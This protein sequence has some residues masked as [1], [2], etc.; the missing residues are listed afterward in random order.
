MSSRYFDF[1]ETIESIKAVDDAGRNHRE[2]LLALD[3]RSFSRLFYGTKSTAAFM[4]RFEQDLKAAR[5]ERRNNYT[6]MITQAKK[7]FSDIDIDVLEY[8][9]A[10]EPGYAAYKGSIV[11]RVGRDDADRTQKSLALMKRRGLVEV[12]TGL[13]DD[14]GLAAGS[15]YAIVEHKRDVVESIVNTYNSENS[16]LPL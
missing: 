5:I 11:S 13:F 6:R 2:S 3:D 8:L 4:K 12:R 1:D 16:E 15:G 9:M 7:R 10:V 14:D